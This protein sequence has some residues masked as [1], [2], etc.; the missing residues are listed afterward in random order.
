M[1]F[2]HAAKGSHLTWYQF[3]VFTLAVFGAVVLGLR[4]TKLVLDELGPLVY[5]VR[6][7]WSEFKRNAIGPI[8]I[9]QNSAPVLD[10]PKSA[11][12]SLLPQCVAT[13]SNREHTD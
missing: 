10:T 12:E 9:H 6:L 13:S 2:L 11:L 4:A 7:S 1:T 3:V 5:E 8:G